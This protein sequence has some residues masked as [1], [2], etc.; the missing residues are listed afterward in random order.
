MKQ[1]IATLPQAPKM[2]MVIAD[3]VNDFE[4]VITL[5]KPELTTK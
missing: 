3:V 5:I 4:F 2:N 1:L